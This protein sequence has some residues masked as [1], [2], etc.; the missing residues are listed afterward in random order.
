[1]LKK[2]FSLAAM[3]GLAGSVMWMGCSSDDPPA[4]TPGE[5]DAGTQTGT[6]AGNTE[7]DS[8]NKQPEKDAGDKDASAFE[9]VD[10]TYGKC[11]DFAKCGG[12]VTGSWK[13]SGGCVSD[14]AF[15]E[16]KVKCPGL[17]ESD[18][19]IKASGTV[20]ATATTIQRKTTAQITAKVSVPKSC[21]PIPDC[22]LIAG[23]LQSGAVPG[24]PKF[25]K[26]TC[27]DSGANCDCDVVATVTEDTDDEYTT[28]GNVLTTKDPARTFDYC[29]KADTVTYTETTPPV[30]D[31][32]TLPFVVELTK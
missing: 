15:A 26:A 18:V 16:A 4:T 27:A 5:T 11:P 9:G 28:S 21:S 14:D 19:A 22:S 12:D 7:T 29:A 23:G 2:H 10:I 8:G 6:D 32:F 13:V 25:E 30:K 3:V 31:V 1:M 17:Q 24:A 20:V